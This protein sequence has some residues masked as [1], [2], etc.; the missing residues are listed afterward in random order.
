MFQHRIAME[1]IVTRNAVENLQSKWPRLNPV[2]Q[3][4]AL[5]A[6]KMAECT[7]EGLAA[8]FWRSSKE[9]RR[10]LEIAALPLDA[11]AAIEAGGNADDYL[12]R[13][14][15]RDKGAKEAMRLHPESV[16]GSPS[17]DLAKKILYLLAADAP[18]E[19]RR[20]AYFKGPL[21]GEIGYRVG[22]LTED[23]SSSIPPDKWITEESIAMSQQFV[24][25]DPSGNRP[26]GKPAISP[27][28]KLGTKLVKYVMQ[29][30]SCLSIIGNALVKVPELLRA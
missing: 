14:E 20:D 8:D 30:E 1:N 27:L 24:I 12:L 6:L 3:G 16:D 4:Q 5:D 23:P 18:G 29:R 28:D 17:T 19:C 15:R 11:R 21:F 22:L 2:Q 7:E 13:E 10:L 26:P 25:L 9:I